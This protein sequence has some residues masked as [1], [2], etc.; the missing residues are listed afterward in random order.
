[1]ND[2]MYKKVGDL[3]DPFAEKD[4]NGHPKTGITCLKCHKHFVNY[5]SIH[6]HLKTCDPILPKG[7]QKLPFITHNEPEK[8]HVIPNDLL[9]ADRIKL[10]EAICCSGWSLN[11]VTKE[12]FKNLVEAFN[13][14]IKI[15]NL[16]VLRADVIAYARIIQEEIIKE[17]S[18][19]YFSLISDGGTINSKTF[20]PVILF[21]RDHLYF[22]GMPRIIEATANNLANTFSDYLKRIIN[23]GG[24]LIATC[25]DNAANIT[26]ATTQNKD[27]TVESLTQQNIIRIPC[28]VHTANLALQD[29][30]SKD[31]IFAQLVNEIS[32]II[33]VLNKKDAKAILRL[34]G[35]KGKLPKWND[36]KWNILYDSLH[37]IKENSRTVRSI[38]TNIEVNKTKIVSIPKNLEEFHMTFEAYANFI[39]QIQTSHCLLYEFY[40]YYVEMLAK[41][42][43]I[44]NRSSQILMNLIQD[45]FKTTGDEILAELCFTMTPQGLTSFRT[46]YQ[47]FLS[48][49]SL[50]STTN[51]DP[52]PEEIILFKRFNSIIDK[53]NDIS[54]H[55]GLTTEQTEL[56]F[57]YYLEKFE[58]K[59]DL[60]TNE[61]KRFSFVVHSE[62]QKHENKPFTSKTIK[63]FIECALKLI[64]LPSSEAVAERCFSHLKVLFPPSKSKAKDDLMEAEMII[65]IKKIFE[66]EEEHPS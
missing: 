51:E 23:K 66:K 24:K 27:N 56:L 14:S 35:A 57:R 65:R 63:N 5:R 30:K 64:N 42:Q 12:S 33:N 21:N 19:H 17:L 62:Y 54:S 43:A 15:P 34:D 48:S 39:N 22:F 18:N 8:Q 53:F 61:W 41:L 7:Q 9:S 2:P 31:G 44:N 50:D 16:K 28:S 59:N 25:T 37:Y 58:F 11:T 46:K 3:D 6:K 32:T 1:M 10:I 26:R 47:S 45:R 40:A 52:S 55:Y 49:G 4:D 38:L 13:P 29:Y 20:Y 36:I 60:L